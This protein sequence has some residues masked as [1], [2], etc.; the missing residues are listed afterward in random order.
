[1]IKKIAYFNGCVAQQSAKENNMATRAICR[2]IGIELVDLPFHCCGGGLIHQVDQKTF[3]EL[4]KYNLNLLLNEKLD[5]LTICSI[6][7]YSLKLAINSENLKMIKVISLEEAIILEFGLDRLEK[8][9]KKRFDNL[10]IAPFYGCRSLRPKEFNPFNDSLNPYFL[11]DFISFLG[12]D[13]IDYSH[14]KKCCGFPD[15]YV[16]KKIAIKMANDIIYDA[17][18]NGSELIVTPCPLCQM[19]L[20][21]YQNKKAKIPILHFS[22]MLGIALGIPYKELGL[23]MNITSTKYLRRKFYE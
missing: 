20:D 23:D 18:N 7:N 4:N 6:C 9:I 5:V 3:Q 13:P 10:K 22:Q 8:F 14:S 16:N 19:M 11:K 12:G 21:I 17:S 1:M 2:K 15:L